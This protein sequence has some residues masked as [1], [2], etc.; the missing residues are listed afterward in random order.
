M[1]KQSVA[2]IWTH[3]ELLHT[4]LDEFYNYP[5]D[6]IHDI[7]KYFRNKEGS[8]GTGRIKHMI[9]EHYRTSC[10][11]YDCN[12]DI[13]TSICVDMQKLLESNNI[14]D[15]VLGIIR[16]RGD[17]RAAVKEYPKTICLLRNISY[18]SNMLSKVKDMPTTND[19]WNKRTTSG[20]DEPAAEQVIRFSLGL[21][22]DQR[23]FGEGMAFVISCDRGDH[24]PEVATTSKSAPTTKAL[25]HPDVNDWDVVAVGGRTDRLT[26][27]TTGHPETIGCI[28]TFGCEIAFHKLHRIRISRKTM[29]PEHNINPSSVDG[30]INV[31]SPVLVAIVSSLASLH[32]YGFELKLKLREAG[33]ACEHFREPVSDIAHPRHMLLARYDS[34]N[35]IVHVKRQC[36]D[37]RYHIHRIRGPQYNDSA[38]THDK[39]RNIIL[40]TNIYNNDGKTG[41]KKGTK[42]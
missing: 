20:T 5:L 27:L 39:V 7:E 25:P 30:N 41:G 1:P 32:I 11:D 14:V 24:P 13:A 42:K 2:I 40:D 4:L 26:A 37:V 38:D 34:I 15:D 36:E 18:L 16:S 6:A 23:M 8:K 35:W 3:T 33:I 29:S 17:I 19:H 10:S 21:N 22:Y 31:T 28:T 9:R 12:T